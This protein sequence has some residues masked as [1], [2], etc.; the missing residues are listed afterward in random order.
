[1]AK[2][3]V[4]KIGKLRNKLRPNIKT[5]GAT[6]KSASFQ[7]FF[8]KLDPPKFLG[9]CLEYLEWKTKW[10]AVVST[11]EQPPEF[12]LDRIKENIP[13]QARK[14]FKVVR[15]AFFNQSLGYFGSSLRR[16]KV[17]QS[18][19]EEQNEIFGAYQH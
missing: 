14:K 7:T 9:D 15:C 13:E 19:A 12:E 4:V 10:K 17:D 8:K 1:M 6:S 11:C 18:E 2:E 5:T 3:F 16:Y